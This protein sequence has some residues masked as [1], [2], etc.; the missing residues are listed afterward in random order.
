MPIYLLAGIYEMW[1]DLL[2]IIML[3]FYGF[4]MNFVLKSLSLI[5]QS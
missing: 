3:F 1:K 4:T 2:K 5:A